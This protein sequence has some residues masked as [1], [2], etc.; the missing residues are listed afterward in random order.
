MGPPKKARTDQAESSCSSSS[1]STAQPA[2]D[3]LPQSV[4]ALPALLNP[5]DS[6]QPHDKLAKCAFLNKAIADDFFD[7]HL[8]F[9]E[10]LSKEE[11]ASFLPG[12]NEY[13]KAYQDKGLSDVIYRGAIGGQVYYIDIEHQSRDD[14]TMPLRT[15]MYHH[16]LVDLHIEQGGK[17]LPVTRFICLYHNP[18]NNT[19]WVSNR[20]L[21]SCFIEGHASHSF[22]GGGIE[23]FKLID[24]TSMKDDVIKKHGKA[25][26][27]M[28]ALRDAHK[29]KTVEG[30]REYFNSMVEYI[31]KYVNKHKYIS[32]GENYVK[33]GT[34]FRD[35]LIEYMAYIC[36]GSNTLDNIK[37]IV[38]ELFRQI[39]N[40][41]TEE[42]ESMNTIEDR[43]SKDF[44]ETIGKELIEQGMRKRDQQIAQMIQHLVQD[45][46]KFETIKASAPELVDEV[47]AQVSPDKTG[48]SL[49]SQS[50]QGPANAELLRQSMSGIPEPATSG[51][52]NIADASEPE[53]GRV[54]QSSR[55]LRSH[56]G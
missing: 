12:N 28:F 3:A 53:L 49:S 38:R 8:E 56:K 5:P 7:A 55:E 20:T 30:R 16:S 29:R 21:D 51:S 23:S 41:K 13:Q 31:N 52:T 32:Y 33:H 44:K 15:Y 45:G 43:L 48:S 40:L 42:I 27:L 46:V 4:I 54:T 24:L 14:K 17:G 50:L 36:K 25:A 11:R 35:A 39:P 18:N 34:L 22:L 1:L 9:Y 6:Y 19:P 2:N 10:N 37:E 26:L 47:L